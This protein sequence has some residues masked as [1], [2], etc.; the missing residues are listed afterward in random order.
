METILNQVI[1]VE[2]TL[3]SFLLALCMTWLML[4]G[5]FRALPGAMRPNPTRPNHSRNFGTE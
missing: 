1:V 5:L 3:L 2:G 4:N